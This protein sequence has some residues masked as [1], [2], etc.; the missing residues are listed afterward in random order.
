MFVVHFVEL[1]FMADISSQISYHRGGAT[2]QCGGVE[3]CHQMLDKNCGNQW[4]DWALTPLFLGD[5]PEIR[6]EILSSLL[7]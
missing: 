5:F 4:L 7:P 6:I 1:K 3:I 2:F